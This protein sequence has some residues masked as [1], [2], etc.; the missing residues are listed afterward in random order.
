MRHAATSKQLR[1][2]GLLVGGLFAIIGVWP[3]VWRSTGPRLWALGL[4]VLLVLPALARPQLLH[5]P[6]RA[7]MVCG[8][9]LGW[10]NTRLLLG[11]LFYGLFTP[12]A[13]LLRYKGHDSMRR[14]WDPTVETYRQVREPRPRSHL[15]Q[16]F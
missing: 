10:I 2:F 1:S 3:L 13:Q 14:K 11:L 8:D 9:T 4:A 12:V 15:R 7:W 5:W 6:Y 16:Q